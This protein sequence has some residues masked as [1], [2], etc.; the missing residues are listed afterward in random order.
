MV[1]IRK[2]IKSSHLVI[3]F[4]LVLIGLSGYSINAATFDGWNLDPH[5]SFIIDNNDKMFYALGEDLSQIQMQ[6]DRLLLTHESG[7]WGFQYQGS[8]SNIS[9]LADAGNSFITRLNNN[10]TIATISNNTVYWSANVDNPKFVN[11]TDSS[12][13]QILAANFKEDINAFNLADPP[14]VFIDLS[15]SQ[16]NIKSNH[17]T[18]ATVIKISFQEAVVTGIPSLAGISILI[19]AMAAFF[20]V[21]LFILRR[22][23]R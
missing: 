2:R 20:F 5:M 21:F 9:D 4:S 17:T 18:E 8:K 12:E 1:G 11:I 7:A 13:I 14:A 23:K 19:I 16:I 6:S 3:A 22:K 10:A 15:N